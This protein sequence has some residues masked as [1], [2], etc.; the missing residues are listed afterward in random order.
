VFAILA[1]VGARGAAA[2]LAERS[3]RVAVAML[4]IAGVWTGVLGVVAVRASRAETRV[5][6]A[7]VIAELGAAVVRERYV[8]LKGSDLDF[9]GVLNDQQWEALPRY[10]AVSAFAYERFGR[11]PRWLAR[12]GILTARDRYR[13]LW[14]LPRLEIAVPEGSRAFHNPRITIVDLRGDG[15]ELAAMVPALIARYPELTFGCAG[16]R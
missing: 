9:A 5:A 16:S 4:V 13:S 8:T 1:V 10:V 2:A 15:G 7:D 11:V 6:A 14:S 3:A 12:G